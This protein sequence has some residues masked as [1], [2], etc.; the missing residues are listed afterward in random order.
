MGFRTNWIQGTGEVCTGQ[1][2][3]FN[4]GNNYGFIACEQVRAWP[5]GP[6]IANQF[7]NRCQETSKVWLRCVPSRQ[8]GH[9]Q[10]LERGPDGHLRGGESEN[11][12]RRQRTNER[13]SLRLG[14]RNIWPGLQPA[15]CAQVGLNPQG[16]PQAVNVARSGTVAFGSVASSCLCGCGRVCARLPAN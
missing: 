9:A 16:K 11:N 8:R 2:K 13:T 3:S 15:A 7:E 6:A 5:L 1:I 12:R 4:P 14:S 10:E